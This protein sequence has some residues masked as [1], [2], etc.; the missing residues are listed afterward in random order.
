MLV[1]LA[2]L[3]LVSVR[4]WWRSLR[5][6]P[7]QD[8]PMHALFVGSLASHLAFRVSSAYIPSQDFRYSFLIALPAAYFVTLGIQGMPRWPRRAA[9]AVWAAFVACSTTLIVALWVLVEP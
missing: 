5:E 6:R 8:F 2:L 1:L 3:G 4:G 9:V 7:W